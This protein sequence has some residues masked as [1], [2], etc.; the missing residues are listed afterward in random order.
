MPEKI[1]LPQGK[2]ALVDDED[3]ETLAQFRW[4]ISNG[5]ATRRLKRK[6]LPCGKRVQC[7]QKM[8]R[9]IMGEPKGRQIDHINENK[10]DNRK[11][12]LR[13]ATAGQNR[14]NITKKKNNTSGFKG[15]VWDKDR[16]KWISQIRSKSKN[17]SLG[18]F[19]TKEEAALA[20]D[21]AATKLHGEFA[22]LNFG[23]KK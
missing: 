6:T 17:H 11:E 20:Y 4:G 10:L 23:G 22:K 7:D 1:P 8:H 3:F 19:K 15:V 12:N 9:L 16:Q 5:Y 13:I 21:V 18:R 2:F 14:C